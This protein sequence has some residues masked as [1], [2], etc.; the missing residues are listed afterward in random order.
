MT[1]EDISARRIRHEARKELLGQLVEDDA[2]MERVY[3]RT[4]LAAFLAGLLSV[5]QR[6]L[7]EILEISEGRV[8]QLLKFL[9]DNS[10]QKD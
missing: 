10:E 7:A 1:F 6:Q 2:D 9:R 5:S 4:M 8:S 3:Q